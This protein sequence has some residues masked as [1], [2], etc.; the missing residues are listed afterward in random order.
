MSLSFSR[1]I[2][3]AAVL[4]GGEHQCAA[5]GHVWITEGGRQC[6]RATAEH[7][8]PVS[9]TVY[10]CQSCGEEDYGQPGGPGHRDCFIEGPCSHR[11]EP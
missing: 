1:L 10:V 8:P 4:A 3:E 5:L 2:A 6:P 7:E 11:C 9:Q